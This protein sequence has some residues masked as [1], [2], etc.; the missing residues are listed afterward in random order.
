[1]VVLRP[2]IYKVHPYKWATI[3]KE[4]KHIEDATMDDVKG[5]FKE[6]YNPSNAV[7]V[8]FL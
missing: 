6:H 4:I 3:G 1:M 8:I 7:L 2:L 5:F